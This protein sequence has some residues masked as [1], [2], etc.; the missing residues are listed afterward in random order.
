MQSFKND[1]LLPIDV[2]LN[3]LGSTHLHT[4]KLTHWHQVVVKE[5]TAF[6]AGAE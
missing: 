4:V 5:S 2:L 1:A 3:N 6:I